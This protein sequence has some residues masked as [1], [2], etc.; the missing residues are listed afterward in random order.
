MI[1]FCCNL[2]DIPFLSTNLINFVQNNLYKTIWTIS[3]VQICVVHIKIRYGRKAYGEMQLKTLSLLVCV[4][5][6]KGVCDLQGGG[7]YVIS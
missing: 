7:G 1:Y 3:N 6:Y 4:V 5:Y 2:A